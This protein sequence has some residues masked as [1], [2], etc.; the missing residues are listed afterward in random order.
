MR[1]KQFLSLVSLVL[2]LFVFDGAVLAQQAV[3]PPAVEEGMAV[4]QSPA[5][6]PP[7]FDPKGM[8]DPFKP[9]IKLV[10]KKAP[11]KSKV[12]AKYLPPIKKYPLNEFRV[13]GIV[14]V[15]DTPKAMV[16]DPEQNTYMLGVGDEIGNQEG[17]IVDIRDNG[18]MVEEKQYTEDVFGKIH[19]KKIKSVL[20]FAEEE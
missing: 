10:Q 16:V 9:F 17:R 2:A 7:P 1:A 12:S 5:P 8:R 4:Q 18:I 6:T 14:W 13:V 11:S 3:R 15:G 19:E 20:A